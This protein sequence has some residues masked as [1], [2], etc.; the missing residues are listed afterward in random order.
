MRSPLFTV[1]VHIKRLA[2]SQVRLPSPPDAQ[3]RMTITTTLLSQAINGGHLES[4]LGKLQLNAAST[5]SAN[6]PLED[7]Q[8]VATKL[9]DP[10]N[11]VVSPPGQNSY[12]H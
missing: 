5:S 3:I 9:V 1:A 6:G 2:F 8:K 4:S 7:K 11:Y 12:I 10:F